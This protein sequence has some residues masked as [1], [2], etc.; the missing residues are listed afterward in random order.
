MIFL[1]VI[2]NMVLYELISHQGLHSESRSESVP[3]TNERL[4]MNDFTK[5][6][7]LSKCFVST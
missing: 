1:L 2:Y 7:T 6:N 5:K 3:D 4:K